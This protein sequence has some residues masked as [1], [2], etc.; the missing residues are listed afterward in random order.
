MIG[1]GGG[2][3]PDIISGSMTLLPIRTLN[4][5]V[6]L[7]SCKIKGINKSEA[8]ESKNSLV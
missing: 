1:N 6:T 8:R 2:Q 5:I 4:W 3:I 7:A